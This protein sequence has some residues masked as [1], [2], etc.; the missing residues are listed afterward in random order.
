MLTA[1][2][3]L[4]QPLTLLIGQLPRPHRLRHRHSTLNPHQ[5]SSAD[6]EAAAPQPIR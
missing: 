3:D 2:H 1:V 6:P 5:A 4:L